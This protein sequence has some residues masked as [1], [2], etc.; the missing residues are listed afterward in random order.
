MPKDYS[1]SQLAAYEK[2]PLQYKFAHLLK[3]PTIDKGQL[4][5]G[6]LVHAVAEAFIGG[7]IERPDAPMSEEE[8]VALYESLWDGEWYEDPVQKTR[9]HDAGRAAVKHIRRRTLEE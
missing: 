6:K 1:Y 3:I 5:F 7:L 2:C 8:V 4:N 9:F